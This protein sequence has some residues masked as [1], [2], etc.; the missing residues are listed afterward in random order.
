MKS[1]VV[2]TFDG[3]FLSHEYVVEFDDRARELF[4]EQ[5]ILTREVFYGP[6]D[7]VRE[8]VNEQ[9]PKVEEDTNRRCARLSKKPR[10]TYTV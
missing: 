3:L 4:Y 2:Q 10:K 9:Q 5:G 1:L 7:L 8:I 6:G